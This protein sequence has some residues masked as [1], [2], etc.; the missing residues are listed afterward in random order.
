MAEGT[1]DVTAR[2]DLRVVTAAGALS[3]IDGLLAASGGHRLMPRATGMD[4]LDDILGGGFTP[5]ELVLIGGPPGVGKTILALQMARN[6]ARNGEHP[7]FACYEHEPETLLLRLLSMEAAQGNP[8]GNLRKQIR[9]VMNGQVP[10][11]TDFSTNISAYPGGADTMTEL[12]GYA[13]RLVLARASGARTTVEKLAA[14]LDDLDQP[15]STL[16]VDYL[17]KIPLVPEPEYEAEKVTRTVEALK[18]LAL[19]RNIPVVLLSAVDSDGMQAARLRLHH[20]RGSSAIA[21][22]S[23]VVLMLN[24]KHRAVS[25]VHLS[26][27][28]ARARSFRDWVV[29]SVEKNRGGPNLIDLEYRKDF[30]SFRFDPEGRL[31]SERLVDER[32]D[33]TSY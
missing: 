6:M 33:E 18:D 26:Y 7:L 27:D 23:D 5:G 1:S 11:H 20:L 24:E 31:V 12:S 17:Q 25:K 8:D 32:T 22:E 9:K 30:P 15:P 21:F 19:E 10:S 14:M 29:V 4:L 28:P 2:H 13:D 3:S 16:F